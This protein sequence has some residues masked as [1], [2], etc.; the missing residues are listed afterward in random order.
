MMSRMTRLIAGL[1][2]GVLIAAG[3]VPASAQNAGP[4][5]K[6]KELVAYRLV[7]WR[8]AHFDDE[9]AAKR[10]FETLKRLG[11]EAKMDPHGGHIDVSWRCPKWHE[12]TLPTHSAAHRWE[13]WL[14]ASGFETRHE[15]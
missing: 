13:D 5:P 3:T 2:A 9:T 1:A 8:T 7:E 10:H 15:H 6:P 14:K 12:I 4:K 11:C